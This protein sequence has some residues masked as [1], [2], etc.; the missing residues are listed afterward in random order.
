[1]ETMKYYQ[2]AILET[3]ALLVLCQKCHRAYRIHF[4]LYKLHG[5][6]KTV[7]RQMRHYHLISTLIS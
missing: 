3:F 1:M 6:S 2:N 7:Q 4:A 5:M